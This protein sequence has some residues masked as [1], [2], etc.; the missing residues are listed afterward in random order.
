M[1]SESGAIYFLSP[2]TLNTS[3]GGVPNAPNLYVVRPGSA[4]H[5]VATLESSLN[6]PLPTKTHPALPPIGSFEEPTGVAV[7]SEGNS[8][9]LDLTNAEIGGY[10]EK[11]DSNGALAS[12]FGTNGK[13]SGFADLNVTEKYPTELAVDDDPSSPSLAIY[14]FPTTTAMVAVSLKSSAPRVTSRARSALKDRPEWRSI[15]TLV[16]FTCPLAVE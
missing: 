6:S 12:S 1:A 8:Y 10:V 5:F 4:P 11:F 15:S 7:D 9:V 3:E 2:E 14:M 16:K 13:L